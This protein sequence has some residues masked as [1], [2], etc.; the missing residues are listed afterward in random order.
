MS[1]QQ[2]TL[3]GDEAEHGYRTPDTMLVCPE[4]HE[5]VLR[6]RVEDHEHAQAFEDAPPW[7]VEA[8][9]QDDED[10]EPEPVGG[11]FDVRVDYNVTFRVVVGAFDK[12]HAKEVA[13]DLIT[14]SPDAV[15]WHEL[16]TDVDQVGTILDDEEEA[17]EEWGLD[18]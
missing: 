6:S 13:Q 18:L 5:R 1:T 14:P 2:I 8:S 16:Y 4:C 9:E 11:M 7:K 12:H 10:D 15:D 17:I 3:A